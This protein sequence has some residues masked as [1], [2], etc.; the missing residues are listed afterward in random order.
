MIIFTATPIPFI[1]YQPRDQL[2]DEEEFQSQ[3]WQRV[4]QYLQQFDEETEFD[5]DATR[6][7]GNMQHCLDVLLRYVLSWIPLSTIGFE[8][9]QISRISKNWFSKNH[10]SY[11]L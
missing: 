8:S 4:Y 10:N 5:V 2:M 11:L 9:F 7:Y 1:G 6:V 3:K